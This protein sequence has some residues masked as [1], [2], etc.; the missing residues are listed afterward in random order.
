MKEQNI[1]TPPTHSSSNFNEVLNCHFK[2]KHIQGIR[3]L[4]I[5]HQTLLAEKLKVIF[6]GQCFFVVLD[7]S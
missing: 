4:K 3:S 5:R 1:R 2:S 7:T 6:Q